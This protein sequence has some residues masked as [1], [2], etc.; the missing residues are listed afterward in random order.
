MASAIDGDVFKEK[1]GKTQDIV[2]FDAGAIVAER[3]KENGEKFEGEKLEEVQKA[4]KLLS[5]NG[6]YKFF[7]WQNSA[8]LENTI[9]VQESVASNKGF[10]LKKTGFSKTVSALENGM[11]SLE[12]DLISKPNFA[13]ACP[14]YPKRQQDCQRMLSSASRVEA[15]QRKK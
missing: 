3:I 11:A 10:D 1:R 15:N 12:L 14:E 4:L 7:K 9:G 13:Y 2:D 6:C 5:L 8:Q